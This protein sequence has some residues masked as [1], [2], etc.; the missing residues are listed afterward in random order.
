[1]SNASGFPIPV[2]APQYQFAWTQATTV[3]SLA[4]IVAVILTICTLIID[5]INRGRL[6]D[7]HEFATRREEMGYF[8]VE[9]M[10]WWDAFWKETTKAPKLTTVR[11]L[12]EAGDDGLWS[13][14]AFDQLE[15]YHGAVSWIPIYS[16]IYS[17]IARDE[18][19][20]FYEEKDDIDANKYLRRAGEDT[21]SEEDNEHYEELRRTLSNGELRRELFR[22][23][24]LVCCIKPFDEVVEK[25]GNI[26][27]GNRQPIQK[28]VSF[29]TTSA[30]P[31]ETTYKPPNREK[32]LKNSEYI[33]MRFGKPCIEISREELLALSL[34]L[35]ITLHI[36]DFTQNVRGLGPFGTGLDVVQDNGEWK[37]QVVHGARL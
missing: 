35:G 11:G 28:S 2:P 26:V 23:G 30:G 13:S 21:Y 1:M 12:I 19:S 14:A 8:W 18:E 9:K 27:D 36:N 29:P 6:A 7:P 24:V 16:A 25:P 34:T 37:L 17:Q 31:I 4:G 5:R 10:G 20:G 22:T 15:P 3:A 33:W 32:S